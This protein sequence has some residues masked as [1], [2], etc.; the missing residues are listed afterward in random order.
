MEDLAAR[1]RERVWLS[2]EA[3]E[4]LREI[5]KS[6]RSGKAPAVAPRRSGEP[7]AKAPVASS[8][9]EMKAAL[10]AATAAAKPPARRS[11]PP[12]PEAPPATRE[13]ET[14]SPPVR[15]VAEEAGFY[16]NR[17]RTEAEAPRVAPA[18]ETPPRE[19]RGRAI[20]EDESPSAL[21][22]F[23]PLSREEKE[24]RLAAVR[25]RA[26]RGEKAR[27]LG[28]LREKMVFAVGNPDAKIMFVGEAP[29]A[30]EERLGEPFVG[31]AGQLLTKILKAM[32][33]ERADVYISNICKYRPAMPNQ[34]TGNRPPTP[35]EMDSCLEFVLEEI[36]IVRPEVIVALGSTAAQGLLRRK[37][38]VGRL[39]GRFHDMNGTP[40]MVTFHPAYLLRQE[41]FEPRAALQEKRK[42]WEDMLRVMERAE[43]PISD[44]Q[45]R[46]FLNV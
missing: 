46:Y 43:M 6:A 36:E 35:E 2:P 27:A 22:A 38:S 32:G 9:A 4:A 30:D 1:G 7:G 41:A 3:R 39:R 11:I 17:T 40:V 5:V 12:S 45:R 37:E 8:F 34:T 29:G 33:L 16:D 23:T 31:K 44:K 14:V 15:S 28:T 10:A 13:S 24:R 18:E 20:P 25:E 26:E 21:P 19:P 42:L